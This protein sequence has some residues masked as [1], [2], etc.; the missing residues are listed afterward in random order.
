MAQCP[1]TRLPRNLLIPSVLEL[2]AREPIIDRACVLSA[3]ETAPMNV[4]K[5]MVV[6][7][8]GWI[9]Q[10]QEDVMQEDVID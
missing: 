2:P 7:L 4:M 6:A 10:R 1:E 9:S 5:L 8:A 3:S